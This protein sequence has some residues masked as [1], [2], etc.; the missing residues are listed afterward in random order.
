MARVR[1][2]PIAV[3]IALAYCATIS[4][5]SSGHCSNYL[6]GSLSSYSRGYRLCELRPDKKRN[7]HDNPDRAD[8][9]AYY[10]GQDKH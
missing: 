1:P 2:T 3:T 10:S 5:S 4:P 6:F 9:Q 8:K 7:E